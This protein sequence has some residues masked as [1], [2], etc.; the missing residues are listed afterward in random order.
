MNSS[1]TYIISHRNILFL[2]KFT[3]L[4]YL[5]VLKSVEWFYCHINNWMKFIMA[6]K[7]S[8]GNVKLLYN[9]SAITGGNMNKRMHE[10][11]NSK[12]TWPNFTCIL[13]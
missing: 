12:Y 5:A 13:S 1:F 3:R 4:L 9:L 7:L 6:T 10:W 8:Q 11:P 2:F